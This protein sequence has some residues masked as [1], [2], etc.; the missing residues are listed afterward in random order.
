MEPIDLLVC[1]LNTGHTNNL[2][3]PFNCFYLLHRKRPATRD[4]D[5][6]CVSDRFSEGEGVWLHL[7][8]SRVSWC[9]LAEM[10]SSVTFA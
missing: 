7:S 4:A 5:V 3:Y 10:R 1:A 2:R 8:S 9:F 6:R